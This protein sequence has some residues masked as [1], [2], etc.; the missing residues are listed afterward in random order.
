MVRCCLKDNGSAE[1]SAEPFLQNREE[2]DE[3]KAATASR[4]ATYLQ[5][6]VAEK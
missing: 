4:A 3:R 1:F 5:L 6:P 2:S